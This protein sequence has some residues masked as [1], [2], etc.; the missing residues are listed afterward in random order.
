MD[1]DT[2]GLQTNADISETQLTIGPSNFEAEG[3]TAASENDN[4]R[5]TPSQS[6]SP[7]G[8]LQEPSNSSAT[9]ADQQVVHG[10]TREALTILKPEFITFSGLE[11]A[12]AAQILAAFI[13]LS[14]T[15]RN[16]VLDS[17][18]EE[19]LMHFKNVAKAN[20]EKKKRRN[21]KYTLSPKH[22]HIRRS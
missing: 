21:I 1:V 9:P 2:P 14:Q 22:K 20:L 16:A 13:G 17:S 6:N 15:E 19:L 3:G 5:S 7:L 8:T 10:L 4:R 12:E 11:S 18:H